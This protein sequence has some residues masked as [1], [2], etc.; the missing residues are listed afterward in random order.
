MKL[1]EYQS[2]ELLSKY[3]VPVP[4]GDVT[5][6]P[7]EARSIAERLGG[8]VV[9]KAQVLMGGRGKAGGVKLFTNA[10]DAGNFAK[11]LIGTRLISNQNP[12]GMV[13]DKVL[14]A[15]TI[16][17]AQ[18]FYV[19]VLL[20]RNIQKNIVMISAEGGMEIEDVAVEKPEAIVR[21]PIDPAWGLCDFELRKAVKDAKIPRAAQGQMVAMIK[22]L[23]KAYVEAD[24]DMIEINPC[25]LTPDNKLIA[26][27][28]K[29]SIDENALFR[30]KQYAATSA[31][32]ADD[33]IEAEAQKRGI[34]YVSLGGDIGI[35]GNGAGLVM[36]SLDEINAAGGRPANF[37]DVGGGAQADRVRNCVEI[38]LMDTKVKGLFINIFGGIT[39]VDEVA[40]GVLAALDQIE[41]NIPIVA[42]IEGTAVEEGR[43]ILEGSKVQAAATVQE[44]AKMIVALAHA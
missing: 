15:E 26:A 44:A 16:D 18:E 6:D 5:T 24:A 35:M 33:P 43:K 42:R 38:I 2:K 25:A 22:A 3:G 31:D 30:H 7:A 34:A 28:A 29:V 41:V 39:R 40:K 11:D 12:T 27:D 4:A 13:V 20:D 23:A 32:S 9:V 14:V 17:I 10:A 36:Q 8:N 1:H 19:A 37:L 21:I